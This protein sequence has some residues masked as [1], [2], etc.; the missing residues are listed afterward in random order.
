MGTHT[1]TVEGR[2]GGKIAI[3]TGASNGIGREIALLLGKEG[4]TVVC[5][6]ISPKSRDGSTASTHDAIVEAGGK[7]VFQ[8]AD[9]TSETDMAALVDSAFMQFGRLDIM[10]NNAGIALESGAPKSIWEYDEK[11]F[12]LT[13][14]VN[15]KGVFLGCKHA[16][17]I[18]KDQTPGITGDRG[19]IVNT[20]S[21]LGLIALPNTMAYT[22]SKHACVGITR[23]A[24]LDCAPHRIHVNAVCPGFIATDMT[25]HVRANAD[26][27]AKISAMHPFGG[28]GKPDDIARAVLF[29]CSPDNTYMTGGQSA[30][31][32]EVVPTLTRFAE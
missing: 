10:I 30:K 31:Q 6:D 32:H 4:A 22:A 27:Y 21:I 8:K 29:L 28:F 17:R 26:N 19:W 16:S 25:Q 11:A 14:D 1:E 9:V 18:M 24:A 23:V 3:V 12:N 2:V 5:A 20:A 15:A 7:A 13:L